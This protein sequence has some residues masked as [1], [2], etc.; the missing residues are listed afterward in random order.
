M[1]EFMRSALTAHTNSNGTEAFKRPT[2]AMARDD[3]DDAKSLAATQSQQQK[4]EVAVALNELGQEAAVQRLESTLVAHFEPYRL[5]AKS[6]EEEYSEEP[7]NKNPEHGAAVP[8]VSATQ[9]KL[10]E[11]HTLVPDAVMGTRLDTTA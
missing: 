5:K 6:A 2:Q 1:I 11:L 8:N 4:Q 7:Q 3:R 9:N 10:Q